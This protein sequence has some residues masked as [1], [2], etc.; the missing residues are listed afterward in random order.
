MLVSPS[1]YF[2]QGRFCGSC[3]HPFST[4]GIVEMLADRMTPAESFFT[5]SAPCP[6]LSH[7]L[8]AVF[9]SFGGSHL[10]NRLAGPAFIRGRQRRLSRRG[11]PGQTSP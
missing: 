7:E 11:W 4:Q 1:F 3:S 8:I 6:F 9:S 5:A 10:S 2:L